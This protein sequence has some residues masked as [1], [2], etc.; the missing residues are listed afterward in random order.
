MKHA[1][2]YLDGPK[3][4]WAEFLFLISAARDL[5]LGMRVLHFAGPCITI[6]GSAR[7]QE[8]HPAYQQSRDLA[9]RLA[10]MGFS[11]MTGGGPG[12]MEAANRGARDVGGI[13]LGCNILLPSEQKPNP[14]LDRWVNMKYFFTRKTLL[15]KYSYA[16]VIMPGGFGTLDEMFES[17]T[18]IQTGKLM[19]FPVIIYGKAFHT[20]LLAHIDRMIQ[21]GTIH[22]E[23]KKLIFVSDNPEEIMEYIQ[24]NTTIQR[25]LQPYNDRRPHPWLFEKAT[26]KV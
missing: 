12:I 17:L 10:K 2:T 3:S 26:Q 1:T 16:F 23:D 13:S 8:D 24:S 19:N 11:I 5:L 21:S 22:A 25:I 15:I 7:F 18:L 20:E 14:Y 4:R 9:A 6:F